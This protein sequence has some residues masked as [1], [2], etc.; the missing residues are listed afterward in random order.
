MNYQ[1]HTPFDILESVNQ[2]RGRK[3]ALKSL[4]PAVNLIYLRGA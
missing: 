3:G 4:N 1:F 2:L